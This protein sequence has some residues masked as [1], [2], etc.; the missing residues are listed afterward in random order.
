MSELTPLGSM[1]GKHNT[2]QNFSFREY[3]M[4]MAD[5]YNNSVGDLNTIDG[6]DCKVC[7]NKGFIAKVDDHDSI[8]YVPASVGVKL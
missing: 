5:F 7:K 6:Y 3:Q 2:E 4:Q 1:L 8:V